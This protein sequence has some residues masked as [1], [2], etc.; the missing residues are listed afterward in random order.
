M[1]EAHQ[2]EVEK[3]FQQG[4]IRG[5]DFNK[6]FKFGS[7]NIQETK[8]TPGATSSKDHVR[9][10]VIRIKTIKGQEEESS[11]EFELVQTEEE[12]KMEQDK[13]EIQAEVTLIELKY[14]L[15]DAEDNE[16]ILYRQSQRIAFMLE[17]LDEKR[18][19]EF[20][21]NL[22]EFKERVELKRK[23]KN[24]LDAL[25]DIKEMIENQKEGTM[26]EK[27]KAKAKKNEPPPV[28]QEGRKLYATKYGK[29]YH[30]EQF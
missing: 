4:V 9:I 2:A 16:D 17:D 14:L 13:K 3:Q 23:K 15:Q 6:D 26:H 18:L 28:P 10:N 24:C 8:D 29:K 7:E 27:E 20:L 1:S 30:F 11:G 12:K 22:E 19:D 21:T 5:D 25:E